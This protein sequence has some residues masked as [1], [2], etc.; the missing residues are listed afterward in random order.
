MA[1]LGRHGVV[2]R[3]VLESEGNGWE[4]PAVVNVLSLMELRGT[5]RRGYFVVGLPGLQFAMP[6]TVERLRS[7]YR[8]G[9][10]DLTVVSA[11][12]FA[13]TLISH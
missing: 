12:D 10:D 2:S 11:A 13:Y 3:R 9:K 6:E 8:G 1:L 7:G 5:I 4:W